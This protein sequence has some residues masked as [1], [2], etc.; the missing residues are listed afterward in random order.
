MDSSWLTV[1]SVTPYVLAIPGIIAL[2]RTIRNDRTCLSFHCQPY[3]SSDEEYLNTEDFYV[4]AAITVTNTGVKPIT[5]SSFGCRIVLAGDGRI[6]ES[7]EAV[8]KKLSLGE[9]AKAHVSIHLEASKLSGIHRIEVLTMEVWATDSTGKKWRLS[10]K[11][12]GKLKSEARLI[13]P[14]LVSS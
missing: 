14:T 9:A 8:G 1:S 13:W 2:T 12:K 6:R 10:K 11:E 5:I 4:G 3:M 7:S